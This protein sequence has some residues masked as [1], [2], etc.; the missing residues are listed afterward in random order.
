M[1]EKPSVDSITKALMGLC[2]HNKWKVEQDSFGFSIYF[3]D[4]FLCSGAYYTPMEYANEVRSYIEKEIEREK[5]AIE[6][7]SKDLV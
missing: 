7:L 2:C 6:Q 5:S 4:S 1:E 3:D